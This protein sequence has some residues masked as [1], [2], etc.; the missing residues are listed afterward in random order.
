[1]VFNLQEIYD[2]VALVA[3]IF[4]IFGKIQSRISVVRAHKLETESLRVL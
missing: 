4:E 3:A 2:F 1:M